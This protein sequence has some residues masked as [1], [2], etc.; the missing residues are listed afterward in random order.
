M[1]NTCRDYNK[2]TWNDLGDIDK[3]R[4][5]L[6]QLAPVWAYRLFQYTMRDV[7][8]SEFGAEK[9]DDVI[10]KA[11]RL[12]GF[13]FCENMLNKELNIPIPFSEWR[14]VNLDSIQS[15]IKILTK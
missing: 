7:L 15:K 2:F 11:G 3:G 8:I 5:N 6:G 4:P 10:I 12:A 1:P 9:A 13:H 14:Y